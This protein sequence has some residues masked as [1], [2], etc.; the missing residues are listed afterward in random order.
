MRCSRSALTFTVS[1]ELRASVRRQLGVQQ[2]LAEAADG[3]ERRLQLVRGVGH[4]VAPHSLQPA[5]LARRPG[6]PSP[7]RRRGA[8]ARWRAG[9]AVVRE[10]RGRDRLAVQRAADQVEEV[11]RRATCFGA[12]PL[13]V[14]GEGEDAAA[15]RGWRAARA[16]C[17]STAITPSAMA[18]ISACISARSPSSW[19]SRRCSSPASVSS[20]SASSP[21]SS[22]RRGAG[23]AGQVAGGHGARRAGDLP[24]RPGDGE[25]EAEARAAPVRISATT[26]TPKM[27]RC[28]RRTAAYTS[29]SGIGRGASPAR[30]C[31]DGH[32]QFL[33]ATEGSSAPRAPGPPLQRLADLRA[34]RRGSPASRAPRPAPRSRRAP[35]VARRSASCAGRRRSPASRPGGRGARP[36]RSWS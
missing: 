24:Q 16:R 3:G 9:A 28:T 13:R 22:R 31:G 7:R 25:A 12:M 33:G 19:P 27:P 20:A 21:S 30:R 17:A 35:A 6:T 5:Q 11:L 18:S 15:P 29:R 34:A 4:E 1:R 10:L 32:V 23:A 8:A 26:P 2:R 14:G 36:T